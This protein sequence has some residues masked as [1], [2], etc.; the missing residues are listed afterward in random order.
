[1]GFGK[2]KDKAAAPAAA[3]DDDNPFKKKPEPAGS[4]VEAK[5][6]TI[7]KARRATVMVETKGKEASKTNCCLRFALAVRMYMFML[8]AGLLGMAFMVLILAALN[9]NDAS[10]TCD[11][12]AWVG[13]GGEGSCRFAVDQGISFIGIAIW[14]IL[15]GGLLIAAELRARCL[16]RYFGFLCT[17]TGKGLFLFFCATVLTHEGLYFKHTGNSIGAAAAELALFIVGL[18]HVGGGV[19]QLC[20]GW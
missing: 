9:L 15:F 13:G 10:S 14:L 7:E 11:G 18:M 20:C 1:M 3:Q 4:D 8:G 2:K 6:D 5:L 19:L 12:G 17:T 16:A